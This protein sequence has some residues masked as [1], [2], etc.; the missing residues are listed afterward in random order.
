MLS[1]I[2]KKKKKQK[3]VIKNII[4]EVIYPIWGIFKLFNGT[5]EDLLKPLNSLKLSVFL[6]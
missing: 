1:E 3:I 2:D 6:G 4:Y 5:S